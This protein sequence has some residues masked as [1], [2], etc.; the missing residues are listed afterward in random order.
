VASRPPWV[1]IAG[2]SLDPVRDRYASTA[3]PWSESNPENRLCLSTGCLFPWH[4][5]L[6]NVSEPDLYFAALRGMRPVEAAR[7]WVR[8]VGLAGFEAH[9]PPSIEWWNEKTGFALAQTFINRPRISCLMERTVLGAGCSDRGC[10]I[11]QDELLQLLVQ[12]HGGCGSCLSRMTST[13]RL[14]L[15]IGVFVL[16]RGPATVKTVYE[17]DLARPRV[18]VSEAA[19][20][21]AIHRALATDL[22]RSSRRSHDLIPRREAGSA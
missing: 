21:T 16:T 13:M 11:M 3:I 14:P 5:V 2:G 9:Y 20:R 8:R 22:E 17:I 4:N 18:V 19:I 6:D 10:R 12:P 7:E 1:L 15:P